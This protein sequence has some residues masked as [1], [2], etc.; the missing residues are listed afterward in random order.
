MPA[1]AGTQGGAST[2]P[3]HLDPRFRGGDEE[4]EWDPSVWFRLVAEEGGF[5]VNYPDFPEGWSQGDS[6]EE[7]VAQAADLLKTMV[8]NYMAE[9]RTCPIHPQRM[10]DR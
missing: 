3:W 2:V 4:R 8:A 6:H 9:D 7:A 5:F 10:V 1:K